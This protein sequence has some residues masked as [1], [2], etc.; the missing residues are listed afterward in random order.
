MMLH[1]LHFV[2]EL[3]VIAGN[4]TPC[5]SNFELQHAGAFTSAFL[6]NTVT[7]SGLNKA[8]S[9]LLSNIC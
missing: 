6:N 3:R 2:L 5:F 8:G 9:A 4:C 7:S 1:V